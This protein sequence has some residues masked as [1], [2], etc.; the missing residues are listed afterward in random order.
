M[1]CLFICLE[2]GRGGCLEDMYY[3]L[4]MGIPNRTKGN[5]CSCCCVSRRARSKVSCGV[6]TPKALLVGGIVCE[7]EAWCGRGGGGGGG[8]CSLEDM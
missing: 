7:R 4:F 5:P 1:G 6:E 2:E 8:M 3:M